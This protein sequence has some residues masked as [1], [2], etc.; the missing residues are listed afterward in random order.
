MCI[1]D[2]ANAEAAKVDG[3]GG[4]NKSLNNLLTRRNSLN[5]TITTREKTLGTDIMLARQINSPDANTKKLATEAKARI[6]K[7]MGDL[8]EQRDQL[9]QL[10]NKHPQM[11]GI[12]SGTTQAKPDGSAQSPMPITSESEYAKLPAGAHYVAPDGKVRIKG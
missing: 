5:Q 11:Q 2:R 12:T 10:I 8:Y 9:N 6:D 3:E 1:R 4:G 7:A